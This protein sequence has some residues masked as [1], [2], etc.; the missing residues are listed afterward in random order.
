MILRHISSY[1]EIGVLSY[2]L[3]A[4]KIPQCTFISR[5]PDVG[6]GFLG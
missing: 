5:G 6:N 1:N 3:V 2:Q 4:F